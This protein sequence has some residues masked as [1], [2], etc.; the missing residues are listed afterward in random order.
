M[1]LKQY[2]FYKDYE[3]F[4]LQNTAGCKLT[5]VTADG[6]SLYELLVGV[7]LHV[8]DAAGNEVQVGIEDLSNEDFV[9]V[10][11]DIVRLYNLQQAEDANAKEQ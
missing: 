1:A 10:E 8:V 3:N 5:G 4:V 2:G 9:R 7:E 11:A 6:D